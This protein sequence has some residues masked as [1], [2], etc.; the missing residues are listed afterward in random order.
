MCM[1]MRLS[2]SQP[3]RSLEGEGVAMQQTSS[4]QK[5][6]KSYITHVLVGQRARCGNNHS[7]AC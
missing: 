3:T 6:E 1:G 5:E 4:Q 7:P 2:G